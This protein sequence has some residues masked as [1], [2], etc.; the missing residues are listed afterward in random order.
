MLLSEKAQTGSPGG[1][2]VRRVGCFKGSSQLSQAPR[3]SPLTPRPHTVHT[4]KTPSSLA[5]LT[6]IPTPFKDSDTSADAYCV[7][8]LQPA[9]QLSRQH[10]HN[11]WRSGGGG[12]TAGRGQ[13]CGCQ[14]QIAAADRSVA[15]PHL[16]KRHAGGAR[17]GLLVRNLG[18]RRQS[19]PPTDLFP[20]AHTGTT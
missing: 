5:E 16:E 11:H 1:S 9:V 8:S 6:A 10:P 18:L 15:A 20:K 14:R 12:G 2:Q 4:E 3:S 17:A 19:H 7:H 13:L